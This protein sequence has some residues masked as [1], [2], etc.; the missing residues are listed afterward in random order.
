MT[1]VDI[2]RDKAGTRRDF[3]KIFTELC[4]VAGIKFKIITG[5]IKDDNYHPGKAPHHID[6]YFKTTPLLGERFDKRKSPLESWVAV[7]VENDWRLVDPLLGAGE[8]SQETEEYT[9]AVTDHYFLT[10]PSEFLFSHF[11][12]SNLKSD[13]D[14]SKWQ[15]VSSPISLAKFNSKPVLGSEFFTLGC[16][17]LPKLTLPLESE[18]IIEFAI[19][20][21]EILSYKHKMYPVLDIESSEYNNFCLC[22]T[23]NTDRNL[24]TF[25]IVAPEVGQYYLKLY[26]IP[27][28]E[29]AEEEGGV[30][31]FLA[32]LLVSFTKVRHNVKP[33][34]ISSQPF[35][36]TSSFQDLG[37][38]MVIK[39]PA[40]W[41]DD[42]IVLFV[43]NKAVFKYVHNEGPILSALHIFD[44]MVRKLPIKTPQ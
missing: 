10:E 30:F 2:L 39:D 20:A 6:L 22:T 34:P 32:T 11:P 26:A 35:G 4:Q 23:E 3:V 17:L 42:R 33:W 12:H 19:H 24:A 9:P 1:T 37:V 18:H 31:N 8:Y 36:L 21:P 16:S 25:T 41:E 15:L 5:F 14:Y 40:V 29:L 44:H 28:E 7:F 27:E 38:S 43:G 13:S